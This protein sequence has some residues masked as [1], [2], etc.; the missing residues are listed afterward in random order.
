MRYHSRIVS[1]HHRVA[2]RGY[3]AISGFQLGVGMRQS[4]PST[5][6]ASWAPVNVTEPSRAIVGQTKWPRSNRLA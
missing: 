2:A 1:E 4:S 5:S 6:I 3:T